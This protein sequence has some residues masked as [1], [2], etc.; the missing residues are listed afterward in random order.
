VT[1]ATELKLRDALRPMIVRER[2]EAHGLRVMENG[3][4]VTRATKRKLRY[5]ASPRRLCFSKCR[6]IVMKLRNAA[7]AEMQ[8]KNRAVFS[9]G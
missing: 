1:R 7:V 5:T 2:G 9:A 8:V 3:I 6:L 4:T